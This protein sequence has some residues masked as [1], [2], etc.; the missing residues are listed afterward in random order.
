M[1]MVIS[2]NFETCNTKDNDIC[3]NDNYNNSDGS[4]IKRQGVAATD[5]GN[6]NSCLS[7][8]Y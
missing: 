7:T 3:N 6:L 4:N 1:V 8:G 5:C 2:N